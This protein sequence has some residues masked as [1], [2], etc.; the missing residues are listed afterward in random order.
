MAQK[1]KNYIGGDWVESSSSITTPVIN[2]ATCETIAECPE[3]TR[4]DVDAA[5]KAAQEGFEEWRRTPVLNRV[6]YLFRFKTM[7]EE[8]FEDI[9]K[10]VVEENG[11]TRDEAR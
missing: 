1:L 11:K 9:T 8:R 10:A 5:V 4:A 3:S 2:P 7:M 6:Q